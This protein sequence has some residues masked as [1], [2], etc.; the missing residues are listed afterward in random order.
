MCIYIDINIPYIPIYIYLYIYNYVYMC[1]PN[2]SQVGRATANADSGSAKKQAYKPP[3]VGGGVSCG[4]FRG[5]TN[6]A[7]MEI[8]KFPGDS[9]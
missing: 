4:T 2:Q 1:P 7:M 5:S 9:K 6:I 3:K 8:D